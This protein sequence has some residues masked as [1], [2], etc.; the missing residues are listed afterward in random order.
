MKYDAMP[1]IVS[2]K[3]MIVSNVSRSNICGKLSAWSFKI[4]PKRPGN[5]QLIA[6]PIKATGIPNLIGKN[7]PIKTKTVRA[8]VIVI[9][10]LEIL[11]SALFLEVR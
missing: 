2:P 1:T 11:L 10:N 9:I 5:T 7:A 8:A 6:I 4:D 3:V